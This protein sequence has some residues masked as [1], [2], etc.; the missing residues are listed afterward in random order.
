MI[1]TKKFRTKHEFNIK[2]NP[3]GKHYIVALDIGYSG[4]KGYH[5][6]GYFCFPSFCKKLG[7]N[8]MGLASDNDILYKDRQTGDLYMVGSEAQKMLG[9]L[10]TNETDGELFSRKRYHNASFKILANTALAIAL[11]GKKDGREIFLQTGLPASYLDADA[12]SIKK[13]LAAPAKFSLKVGKGNWKDYDININPEL[14]HVTSQPAGGLHSAIVG[15]DGKFSTNPDASTVLLGNSF[16]MDIGFGTCD[17]YG[18]KNRAIVCTDSIDNIGMRAV[19]DLTSK[20]ILEVYGEDIRIQAL[21]QNLETGYVTCI[22][23]ETMQSE[24]KPIS[25]ILSKSSDA[26]FKECMEKARTLTNTFRDYQYI[27]VSGGTGEAWFEKIK[28]YLSGLK[29][30][31]LLPSNIQDPIP[32][33]YSNVR[34]Y[35]FFRYL[36][37]K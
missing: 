26:V 13:A 8:F 4:V 37:D 15:K 2:T 28:Q 24:D 23:E 29:K 9:T 17:F 36:R 16:V 18:F 3:K 7:K 33:L 22:N 34:G 5:E 30:I 25:D 6:T 19:M 12:P 10:S 21:Q 31:T 1:N 32:F 27:I 35:Y 20:K 14:I 11:D